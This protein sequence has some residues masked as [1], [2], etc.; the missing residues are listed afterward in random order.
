MGIGSPNR[1]HGVP[2]MASFL[3]FAAVFL[4]FPGACEA[5]DP[6]RGYAEPVRSLAAQVVEAAGPGGEEELARRVRLLG[7]AMHA[8]GILSLNGIPD[9]VFERAVREGW[10]GEVTPSLRRVAGVAPLSVQLW[11][12]LVKED[13]LALRPNALVHDLR[14]LAGSVR[15]FG[16]AL[17]GCASWLISFLAAAICWFAAWASIA[18]FLR[19]RPSLES[20]IARL[21]KGPYRAYPAALAAAFLFLLP[22]VGGVGLAVAASFWMALSAGYLRR[23]EFVMM[24]TSI[25]LLAALLAGGSILHSLR[26]MTGEGQRG[27]WMGTEGYFPVAWPDASL[28]P[29]GAGERESIAWLV[30]FSRARAAMLAGTPAEAERLWGELIRDG[31]DLPA[32]RNNRGISMAQQGRLEEGLAEFEEA[33]RKAP[34]DGPALWNAYNASLRLFRLERARALQPLAWDRISRTTPY[35]FR[36]AELGQAE[37]I[38]SALNVG[39]I[40]KSFLGLRGDWVREAGESDVFRLFFRPLSPPASLA[41]LLAVWMA[42]GFWK[43]LSLKLWFHRTCRGC[44]ATTLVVG[45]REAHELCNLCRAGVGGEGRPAAEPDRRS[46]AIAMHRAYVL[47]CSVLVPGSGALWSGKEIRTLVYGLLLSLA[48]GGVS[49]SVGGVETGAIVSDLRSSL[50]LAATGLAAALWLAGAVWSIRSFRRM[51]YELGFTAAKA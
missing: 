38:A 4:G 23:G 13:V 5:A 21:F 9:L 15:R 34:E 20:D 7:T 25:V 16:P 17:P 14:G 36:P 10:K 24:T 30:R 32:I 47:A 46:Q 42:A 48:L 40:W 1:R 43:A 39:E 37:W 49:S 51:Q 35:G 22:L 6:F 29:G 41:F 33:L 45:S 3:F 26:R 19:A 28:L 11:A 12:W 31:R 2:G 27:G 44:G 8:Q 18:L 50:A